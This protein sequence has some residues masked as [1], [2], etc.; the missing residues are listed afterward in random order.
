[1]G[2]QGG[3]ALLS[4][5]VD[6]RLARAQQQHDD[7]DDPDRDNQAEGEEKGFRHGLF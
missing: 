7:G 5:E 4:G 6:R 1:L 3:H 2:V